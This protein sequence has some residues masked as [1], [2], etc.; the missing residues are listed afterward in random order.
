MYFINANLIGGTPT[1]SDI[2]LGRTS[3][4]MTFIEGKEWVYNQDRFWD[5]DKN[6]YTVFY[7]GFNDPESSI[8][9]RVYTLIMFIFQKRPAVWE[10]NNGPIGRGRQTGRR[11]P[12]SF[13]RAFD[14]LTTERKVSPLRY[15][16]AALVFADQSWSTLK[17]IQK[18][19]KTVADLG[20]G[21]TLPLLRD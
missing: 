7:E 19:V 16:F 18:V 1:P 11:T 3:T 13:F 2:R 10:H 12:L 17:F 21:R 6:V 4:D 20:A 5:V 9:K 8:A 15:Y 14:P